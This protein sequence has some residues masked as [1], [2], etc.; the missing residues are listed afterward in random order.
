MEINEFGN[1]PN[2]DELGKMA[3]YVRLDKASSNENPFFQLPTC[4]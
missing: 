1:H 4:S 3:Q 2:D